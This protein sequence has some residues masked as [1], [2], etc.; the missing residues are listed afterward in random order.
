M[1]H[2]LKFLDRFAAFVLQEN[3]V[4]A[5]AQASL[6]FHNQTFEVFESPAYLRRQSKVCGS[7][8]H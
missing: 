3:E 1:N 2:L 8:R 7:I 6:N 5:R 4:L